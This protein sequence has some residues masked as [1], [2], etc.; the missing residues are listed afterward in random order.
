M[1]DQA[2][3]TESTDHTTRIPSEVLEKAARR[4]FTA[5]YKQRILAGRLHRVRTDRRP[6]AP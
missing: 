2:V 1:T 3:R 6:A 4:R 5:D